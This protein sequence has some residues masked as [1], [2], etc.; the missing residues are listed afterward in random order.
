MS[1]LQTFVPPPKKKVRGTS[2]AEWGGAVKS[3]RLMTQPYYKPKE[4]KSVLFRFVTKLTN[5]FLA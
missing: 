4:Y 2:E 3:Q 1:R 5:K